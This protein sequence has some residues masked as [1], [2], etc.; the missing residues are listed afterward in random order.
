MRDRFDVE[1]LARR[2]GVSADMLRAFQPHYRTVSIPK[3]G[4][5]QGGYRD[6]RMRRLS[7]PNEETKALQKLLVKRL[8]RR[9]PVHPAASA[10]ERGKSPASN[11]AAHQSQRVVIKLDIVDFFGST[12]AERVQAYF[13]DLG[14]KE[15]AASILMRLVTHE[16]SLPQGA[17]TSPF[18][19]NRLVYPIDHA[20]SRAWPIEKHGV[21]TRYGD[22]IT[23]SFPKDYPRRIRRVV[24]LVAFVL[25][26]AGYKVHRKKKLRILRQHQQ[27][28]VTGCVVNDG[29]RLSRKKRRW[30]RAVEHHLRTKG[31]A[32]LTQEQLRGWRAWQAQIDAAREAAR[33]KKTS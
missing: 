33:T 21:Y 9:L 15:E 26:R 6:A 28:R 7:V 22:D 3:R 32:S 12:R 5:H 4:A 23:I 10:W 14:W 30:L 17:P 13:R 19:A 1:E 11:A 20:I 18:L 27:Q 8:L 16:G 31:E 2:L 24:Q 29:A 25:E